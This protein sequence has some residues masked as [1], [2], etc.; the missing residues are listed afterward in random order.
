MHFKTHIPLKWVGTIAVSDLAVPWMDQGGLRW[1]NTGRPWSKEGVILKP[2]G[3]G[4]QD[5][6]S[7]YYLMQSVDFGPQPIPTLF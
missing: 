7:E 6:H 4:E 5:K 1:E 3:I 2:V